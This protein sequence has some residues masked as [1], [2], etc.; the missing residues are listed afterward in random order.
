MRP[1]WNFLQWFAGAVYRRLVMWI[2]NCL[3]SAIIVADALRESDV[4]LLRIA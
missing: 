2:E 1:G 4:E 3:S